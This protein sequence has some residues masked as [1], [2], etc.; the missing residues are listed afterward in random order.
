MAFSIENR[1]NTLNGLLFVTLLAIAAT[2]LAEFSL[3]KRLA[4]SPLIISIVLGMLYGNSLRHKFPD[5][6]QVALLF[7]TKTLLRLGIVF[8]GF[9]LTFQYIVQ[10]GVTGILLSMIMVATTFVLGCWFG[11]KVLKLDRDTSILISAGSAICGAAAVLATEPIIKAEP[12]KTS[13]A[14]ATVVVFGTIAMFIYPMLYQSGILGLTKHAMGAFTGGSLHEVAHV[15]GAG[16]AMGDDIANTAI[17]VKMLRVM[18]LAPFLMVL[19]FWIASGIKQKCAEQGSAQYQHCIESDTNGEKISQ[20]KIP[21][22]IPWFALGFVGVV[23]FN[24]LNLLPESVVHGVNQLD[25]FVLTMAMTALGM[26]TRLN[27]FKAVGLKPIYLASIL[28]VYLMG[29][30]YFLSYYLIT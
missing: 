21:I 1:A 23:G 4:I 8:Y 6:W 10:V 19:S 13:I 29:A 27:K 22:T 9:R 5:D 11:T 20:R 7:S 30:G 2:Y 25:N 28:F 17:I 3:F 12:Y 18:M 15:V 26:E 24:S 16:A 14:V